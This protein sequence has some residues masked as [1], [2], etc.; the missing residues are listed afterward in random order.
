MSSQIT[1]RIV[2]DL[3]NATEP[4]CRATAL[5]QAAATLLDD[6]DGPDPDGKIWAARETILTA[7][8]LIAETFGDLD[9]MGIERR[10]TDLC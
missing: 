6:W 5:L 10:I 4:A 9:Q 2:E 8:Q 7:N 1:E 3:R